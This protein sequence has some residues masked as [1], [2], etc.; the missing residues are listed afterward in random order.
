[1]TLPGLDFSQ[2][3]PS[4]PQVLWIGCSDS[5]FE[6]IAA[7]GLRADETIVLRNIGNI[8]LSDGPTCLSTGHYALHVVKVKHVVV[9]G[10]YG[11]ALVKADSNVGLG[12]PWRS[13]L[14]IL[15]SECGAKLNGLPADDRD[16]R[17]VE[18]NVLAQMQVL[19]EIPEVAA[20]IHSR[21]LKIHGMV[22][23]PTTNKVVRLEA[24][25]PAAH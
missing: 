12:D 15:R 13:K 18:L 5:S 16:R 6:E 3:E 22:Y 17:F 2:A 4:Q 19:A 21:G 20:A 23:N 24:E 10:H 9:C 7:L 8:F 11:C 1:M 25:E 14:D